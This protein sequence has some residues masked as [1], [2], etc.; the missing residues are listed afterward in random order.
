MCDGEVNCK[1]GADEL[2]C[3]ALT[4][5]PGIYSLRYSFLL[6]KSDKAF[7]VFKSG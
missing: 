6:F 4:A 2:N 7:V 5:P 3:D 1:N